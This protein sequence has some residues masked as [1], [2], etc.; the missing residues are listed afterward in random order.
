MTAIETPAGDQSRPRCLPARLPGHLRDA[1][2]GR[3]TAG[4][5]RYAATP[6]IRSPA[7]GCASRSTT[8]W[9]RSTARTGCCTRCGAPG[10]KGSGRFERISWDDA[11]DEIAVAVPRDDRRARPRGDHAG[12]LS[13]H[14]GHPQRAQRRRPV[15][16]QARRDD[17]RAHL[18][19]LR[20]LH[21]VHDDHRRHRGRR[22]GEPGALPLHRHLGLQHGVDQPAPV[23]VRRRGAAARREGRGDRPGAAP[24]GA[25]RRLAHPD[26]AGHR[27]RARAGDDARDHRRGPDR[28]GLRPRPHRRLR[29]ARRAGAAVHA[30][31][32]GRRR[33]ASPPRTSARWPAS[34]PPRSRR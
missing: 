19:R 10:P 18:L 20:R 16:Q 25:A 14:R 34:T 22:P 7:A 13:G 9:T 17:L 28:R 26:P 32:G 4:P 6:S 23:A 11:L 27:R 8:T 3:P 12:Q 1:R 21:R 33:P 2:D 29:R 30:G 5:P 24:D 31:V 15:L